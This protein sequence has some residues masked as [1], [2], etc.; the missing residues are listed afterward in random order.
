MDILYQLKSRIFFSY[1]T[2]VQFLSVGENDLT[3]LPDE[4]GMVHNYKY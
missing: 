4:I 2:N 1:L 3:H